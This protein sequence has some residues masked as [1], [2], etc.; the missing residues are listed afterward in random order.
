VGGVALAQNLPSPGSSGGAATSAAEDRGQTEGDANLDSGG[1]EH[2]PG[3]PSTPS[4]DQT[5]KALLRHGRVV[6]RPRHFGDDALRGRRLLDPDF[7]R[8]QD[9]GRPCADLAGRARVVPAEYRHAPAALVFR[10]P[11]GGSQVVDLFVCGASEPVR[12][13]TLPAP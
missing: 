11:E 2:S 13:T 3:E 6:V 8:A 7:A 4:M 12:S 1:S 9:A 5:R 10:R